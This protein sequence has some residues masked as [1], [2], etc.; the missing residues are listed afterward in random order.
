[1]KRNQR[2]FNLLFGFAIIFFVFSMSLLFTTI[3]HYYFNQPKT[4]IEK[5]EYVTAD[6]Y[7]DVI[8]YTPTLQ[9]ELKK[10]HLEKYTVALA[11]V[12]HQESQGKGGDPMQS[13]ESAGLPP[14]TIKEPKES[15]KQGVKHFHQVVT[16]GKKKDVDFSTILQAYNMGLGYI[17]FI[18]NNGGKHTEELAMEF[19]MIQVEKNPT[20]YN[21]G[22]NRD[23]FRY[24]YCYGDFSYSTKVTK[25]INSLTEIID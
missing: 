6:T 13:S 5:K 11:A 25:N 14:N 10:Y 1:M 9:D 12:M 8:K 15:I 2:M 3:K 23:N 24:P 20:V 16:Y 17:N 19:S 4:T 18:S 21:C 22:G 7:S